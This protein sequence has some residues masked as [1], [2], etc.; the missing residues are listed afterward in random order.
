M[1]KQ[2][3]DARQNNKKLS[4][5]RRTNFCSSAMMASLASKR[6]M[7]ANIAPFSLMRPS[8]AKTVISGRLHTCIR[9]FEDTKWRGKHHERAR[10]HP[11]RRPVAKS[12]GS[13]AGVTFTA[14]VPNAM[15]TSTPSKI[16]GIWRSW[17]GCCSILPCRACVGHETDAR[18]HVSGTN[19]IAS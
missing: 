8:S 10:T 1:M 3:C 16:M 2:L 12:F 14:P 13:W 19:A 6:I 17:N 15:S 7:P 9:T 4:Q 18:Q 5:N 11:C